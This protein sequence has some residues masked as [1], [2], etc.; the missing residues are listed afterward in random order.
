M[1]SEWKGEPVSSR[2]EQ[3]ANPKWSALNACRSCVQV[4]EE[5]MKGAGEGRGGW[6]GW[7]YSH[8][9]CI[10]MKFSN[11]KGKCFLVFLLH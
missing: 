2:D 1:C 7:K 6:K 9:A 10:Y 11:K 5:G 8:L 4:E 3:A